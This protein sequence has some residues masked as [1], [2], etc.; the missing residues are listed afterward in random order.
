MSR[1]GLPVR[2]TH[3]TASTKRRLFSPLRPGSPGLPRQCASICAHW[4]SVSTSRSIVSLNHTLTR[5]NNPD[6]QQ[7][8]K[9][10]QRNCFDTLRPGPQHPGRSLCRIQR[11]TSTATPRETGM[12]HSDA[13]TTLACDDLTGDLQ[14]ALAALADVEFEFQIACERLDEWSGPVADKDGVRQLLEA[15]RG[16]RRGSLIQRLAELHRQMKPLVFSRSSASAW[17]ASTDEAPMHAP[18]VHD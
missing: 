15:E 2:T 5:A 7:A 1:Q 18:E 17:E 4:A 12:P 6:S 9:R 10:W 14:H 8:L 3:N 16:R 11:L 13:L